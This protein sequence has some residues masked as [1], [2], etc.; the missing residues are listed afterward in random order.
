MCVCLQTRQFIGKRQGG[1]VASSVGNN[2]GGAPEVTGPKAG[3]SEDN[4]TGD[5]CGPCEKCWRDEKLREGGRKKVRAVEKLKRI[6]E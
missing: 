2:A 5:E 1:G 4:K 6:S 3:G